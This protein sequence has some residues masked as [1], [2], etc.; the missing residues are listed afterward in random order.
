MSKIHLLIFLAYIVV[1]AIEVGIRFTGGGRIG[2]EEN[3]S[4]VTVVSNWETCPVGRWT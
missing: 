1:V 2:A 4:R 3:T